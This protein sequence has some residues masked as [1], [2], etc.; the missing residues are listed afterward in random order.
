MISAGLHEV[1]LVVKDVH[2]A[3]AFYR[4]VLG[5]VPISEPTDDWAAFATISPDNPQWIGLRKGPLLFEEFSPR[6]EG[7]RFGPVHFAMRALPGTLEAFLQAAARQAVP[8]HG[9]YTFTG[10]MAGDSYYLYDPDD[11]LVEFWWAA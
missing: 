11:N 5:L 9:P 10:R 4:E 6:P 2:R 8:V 7:Q 3:A 1:V